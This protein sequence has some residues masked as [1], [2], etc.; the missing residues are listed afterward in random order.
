MMKGSA[1]LQGYNAQAAVDAEAQI[2]LAAAV[3]NQAPDQEHLPP[4]LERVVANCGVV[5]AV[6]SA[7]AGYFSLENVEAC[8]AMRLDA[9]IATGRSL[10]PPP[11]STGEPTP[12]K[13][14]RE[15]MAKKL[16]TPAGRAI[17]A[18]RKVIVE[19]VFGQIKEGQRF[20]R[21]SL[22]GI[23]KVRAEW[24]LVCTTHNLLKLFRRG[25]SPVAL[26]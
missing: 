3:T 4:M 18:R 25:L 24:S 14:V 21:F 5:P 1:V 6:A 2:I 11:P 7:D 16:S 12:A 13:H 22:R 19:P 9:H 20:R 15:A 8:E 10:A 26:A 23:A 17:Y